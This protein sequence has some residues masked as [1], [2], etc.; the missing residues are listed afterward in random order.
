MPMPVTLER[1]PIEGLLVVKTGVF[2]DA[3]GFFSESH[4]QMM[5][6]EAGFDAIFVQD[7]LSKSAKGTL[8]GMHYQIE[9]AGMGKLVRCLQGAVYDV[10]VDL[11]R[12]SPSYG[13]WH[14]LELSG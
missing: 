3:R 6:R 14:G 12:G 11:R 7:N 10:V 9:P 5:W 13:K 8:R 4:S 2:H 1:T